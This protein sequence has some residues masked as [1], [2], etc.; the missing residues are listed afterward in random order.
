MVARVVTALL[1]VLVVF[2]LVVFGE[3]AP[4][5]GSGGRL[6]TSLSVTSMSTQSSEIDSSDDETY[7]GLV[8]LDD[9]V[10]VPCNTQGIGV[11]ARPQ[12]PEWKTSRGAFTFV[13]DDGAKVVRVP[14]CKP[15][16]RSMYV[17]E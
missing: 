10:L 14:T 4:K 1:V 11:L 5:G 2:T 15:W 16:L 8:G 17:S 7:L 13:L 9:L 3:A 6:P 12:R